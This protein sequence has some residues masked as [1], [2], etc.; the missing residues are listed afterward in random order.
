[1]SFFFQHEGLIDVNY[2]YN[3]DVTCGPD[4]DIESITSQSLDACVVACD[5]SPT[6]Q[7]IEYSTHPDVQATES[8][9]KLLRNIKGQSSSVPKDL[10]KV[11]FKGKLFIKSFFEWHFG[12]QEAN[13]LCL[14]TDF[15]KLQWISIHGPFGK[16]EEQK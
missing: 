16:Y 15:Q 5:N 10:T 2:G 6:C 8:Y 3:R 9:C 12:N 11:Y 1:M 14:T 4:C 13:V 7:A